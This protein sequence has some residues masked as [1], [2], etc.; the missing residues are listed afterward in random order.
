MLQDADHGRPSEKT[1]EKLTVASPPMVRHAADAVANPDTE[2]ETTSSTSSVDS[3][4]DE[5]STDLANEPE[6]ENVEA[7]EIETKYEGKILRQMPKRGWTQN[8][9]DE[10]IQNP[11]R[12]AETIDERRHKDGTRENDPATV[13]LNEDGSYVVRNTVTGPV[14]LFR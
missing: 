5:V 10:T 1:A 7:R 14:A 11:H 2:D 13:Y 9:V 6:D 8:T 4:E 3:A 12:T